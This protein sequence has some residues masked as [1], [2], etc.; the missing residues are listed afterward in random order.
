MNIG[1]I[2]LGHMGG[3]MAHR[4]IDAGYQLVVHDIDE[5]A[6]APF[7]DRGAIGA[8]SPQKVA[9]AAQTVLMS[10][11]TPAVARE[12]ALGDSGV[13]RGA[14][15]ERLVD[16]STVG[17]PTAQTIAQG[18]AAAGVQTV[19]SPVSGGVNGAAAGTLALMVACP[20]AEYDAVG[21]VLAVL[22]KTFHVGT[23]PGQ[24]QVM[25]L[26]NNYLSAAALATSTEALVVG[27]K[28]GLDP[29]LMVD[30]LNVSSGRN[31]ATLDKIPRAV[32]PGTFDC[33]FAIGLMCKDLRLFAAQ[34][35]DL[36]VPLWVGTP[37][38]TLYQHASDQLGSEVDLSCIVQPLEQ[39]SKT[40]VRSR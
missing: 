22:G 34:A 28:A 27:A 13:V 33:G 24:G 16:L 12:V 38:R 39:W 32:L 29:Q 10:V 37:I 19:D 23:N 2:G 20:A 8:A 4:L 15:V 11:P 17:A 21:G 5:T 25:K 40:Q 14:C 30:V 35:E 18:L 6:V 36:K 7:L 31:S 26:L 9:D 1:F 3:P